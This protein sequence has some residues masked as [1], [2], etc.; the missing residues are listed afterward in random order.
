MKSTHHKSW[1]CQIAAVSVF[2]CLTTTVFAQSYPNSLWIGTDN[3]GTRDILNTDRTGTLLR[4]IKTN[5]ATGIALDAANNKIFFGDEDGNIVIRDLDTLTAGQ[6]LTNGVDGTFYEG[7]AF[8]GSNIWR[9]SARE[10]ALVR[11]SPLDGSRLS[12]FA[13]GYFPIGV[14]WDGT[15]LWV[16]KYS[17]TGPITRYNTNGVQTGQQFSVSLPGGDSPGGLAYDT[18]DGTLWV[19]ATDH[20]YHYSTNGTYLGSFSLPV[21]AEGRFVD[22]LAF[23][24]PA[25]SAPNLSLDFY[26]GITLTGN[27][28]TTNSIQY[29][30]NLGDTNWI[31]LTNLVLPQSPYLFF[32]VTSTHTPHRFYRDVQ[33]P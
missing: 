22:G 12:S 6:P 29:V 11:L 13:L 31:T 2:T 18:T 20:I 5:D 27:V 16:S 30:T 25:S 1:L 15:C 4:S 24:G 26:A 33:L 19:G 21:P 14:A 17:S 9:G 8:D 10:Q 32:D 28:G 3:I 23:Q 7:M